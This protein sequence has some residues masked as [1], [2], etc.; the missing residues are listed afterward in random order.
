[1]RDEEYLYRQDVQQ[2]GNIAR[3]ARSKRTHNGKG[4]RV[5]LPSDN[6][7]EKELKKMNGEVKSYPLNKPMTW[8]QYKAMPDDIKE[9]YIKALRDKFGVPDCKIG[10]MMGVGKVAMSKEIKRIGLGHGEKHGGRRTWDRDG[11]ACWLNGVKVEAPVEEVEEEKEV[12]TAEPPKAEFFLVHNAVPT[13]GAMTFEG[14]TQDIVRTI[15]NLFGTA[16]IHLQI[17]WDVLAEGEQ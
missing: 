1:M 13:S 4:G 16:N 11:F 6:M 3:S 8:V 9:V 2:R 5:R 12:P 17:T 10:E 14:Y 7:T 15:S